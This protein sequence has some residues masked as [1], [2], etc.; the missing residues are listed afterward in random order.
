MPNFCR[1]TPSIQRS[2]I[3]NQIFL[4]SF[5]VGPC[6]KP[7]L[8]EL[9]LEFVLE[10][11]PN[12]LQASSGNTSRLENGMKIVE[13][14]LLLLLWN[15]IEL[16]W[17]RRL[18]MVTWVECTFCPKISDP[19]RSSESG[20]SPYRNQFDVATNRF[21]VWSRCW[22][23]LNCSLAF[24]RSAAGSYNHPTNFCTRNVVCSLL[25][26]LVAVRWRS[27][28]FSLPLHWCSPI[29]RCA[30]IHL[31]YDTL[32][33]PTPG[34]RLMPVD[35]YRTADRVIRTTFSLSQRWS[36]CCE[37]WWTDYRYHHSNSST[38]DWSIH[39]SS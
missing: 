15:L 2:V 4:R 9:A 32:D 13:T 20:R 5:L 23:A 19:H 35:C 7:K 16:T 14:L 6:S 10:F 28:A 25:D 3:S 39:C 37:E 12:G 17:T 22:V 1:S 36:S 30:D 34:W 26:Q 31:T 8:V 33:W 38:Y 11:E 24:G 27:L 18:A 21:S 29:V